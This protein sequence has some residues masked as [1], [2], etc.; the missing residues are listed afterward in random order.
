MTPE[1]VRCLASLRRSTRTLCVDG[2]SSLVSRTAPVS[3]WSVQCWESARHVLLPGN[4]PG[5]WGWWSVGILSSWSSIYKNNHWY[6]INVF[7][8]MERV[9]FTSKQPH[10][11]A[12]FL[13]LCERYWV[14]W[15]T[16]SNILIQLLLGKYSMLQFTHF[17]QNNVCT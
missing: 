3:F 1:S 15:K 10:K 17:K 9:E 11:E 8:T 6:I 16:S 12:S 7:F 5:L 13:V 2:P 14:I 4:Q